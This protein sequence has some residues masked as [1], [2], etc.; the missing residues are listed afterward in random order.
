MYNREYFAHVIL[1]NNIRISASIFGAPNSSPTVPG[2]KSSSF[3]SQLQKC[4]TIA[5]PRYIILILGLLTFITPIWYLISPLLQRINSLLIQNIF[6]FLVA[7]IFL[8]IDKIVSR[9]W[10]PRCEP[11][12]LYFSTHFWSFPSPCSCAS[13]RCVPP[14]RPTFTN[15]RRKLVYW[16]QWE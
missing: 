6:I 5:A 7:F 9:I 2:C 10:S 8:I 14:W 4:K 13:S 3:E 15:K 11:S 1:R 16:D 12:S